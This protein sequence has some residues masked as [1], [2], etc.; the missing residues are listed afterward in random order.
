VTAEPSSWADIMTAAKAVQ[1][2]GVVKYPIAME[3][4]VEATTA[5]PWLTLMVSAG[6]TLLDAKGQPP[7]PTRIRRVTRPP[8]S[9]ARCTRPG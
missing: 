3:L 2:K 1:A 4:D 6:G 7:S 5:E 8:S 9:S